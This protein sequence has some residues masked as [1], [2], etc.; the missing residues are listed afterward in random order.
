MS[1]SISGD[2]FGKESVSQ[3]VID[4]VA[5]ATGRDP[6]DV[7]PLYHVI[8]PDALDRLFAATGA[9]GRNGGHVEFA[10]AGCDVVVRGS[11]SVEVTEHSVA[12]GLGD[13]TR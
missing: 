8:D 12:T 11:G 6:T 2:T 1:Q 5:E 9:G 10:F 13:E 3:R 4:A 7:G